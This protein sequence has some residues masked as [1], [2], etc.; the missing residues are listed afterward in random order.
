MKVY[1]VVAITSDISGEGDNFSDI[2]SIHKSE[3]NART[4]ANRARAYFRKY[5]EKVYDSNPYDVCK[6]FDDINY[7]ERTLED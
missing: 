6:E 5:P 1:I 2:I 4:K 3:K 7:F